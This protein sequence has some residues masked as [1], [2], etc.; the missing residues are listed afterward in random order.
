MFGDRSDAL[1]QAW[2]KPD[3]SAVTLVVSASLATLAYDVIDDDDS[4]IEAIE[5]E[6]GS[7][8]QRIERFAFMECTCLRS[9]C[10]PAS[11]ESIGDCILSGP[12]G[13]KSSLSTLTFD[14]GS[15]LR[16]ID[17][18]TFTGCPH[19]RSLCIPASVES[20]GVDCPCGESGER[21]SSGLETLTFEPGS[22]LRAIHA[23]AFAWFT[24]LQSICLPA[25]V[26][27]LDGSSFFNSPVSTI[28][29]EPGNT[30]FCVRDQFLLDF[31]GVRIIFNFG[32]DDEV[33]IPDRIEMIGSSAFSSKTFLRSVS[34]G[35]ESRLRSFGHSSFA[36]CP[37][38]N[39]FHIPSSVREIG[40]CSF[41]NCR[42]LTCVTFESI[43][44]LVRI[45]DQAFFGCISLQSLCIPSSV[46]LIGKSC[47]AGC[48]VLSTLIFECPSH[49]RA[50][51]SLRQWVTG[52]VDIPDSVEILDATLFAISPRRVFHFGEGSKLS[53]I[54]FS[55]VVSVGARFCW[56]R[57]F[58]RLP[59]HR[60]KVLRCNQEFM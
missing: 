39:V 1:P 50:L 3:C 9:L 51:Q 20:I 40:N 36:E 10:I 17:T 2:I 12:F 38:L 7:K 11:V 59:A 37:S 31:G 5:F 53:R 23:G 8:L 47:Y 54:S 30:H 35:R 4:L 33:Q 49:L 16:E 24:R 60:L 29:I 48:T 44:E 14:S 41:F 27:E 52:S 21:S 22:K 32:T 15:K 57:A 28:S 26:S 42:Q 34:F 6:P 19:L 46:E 25:S 13:S 43:S 55:W 58:V 56:S 18:S 45:G